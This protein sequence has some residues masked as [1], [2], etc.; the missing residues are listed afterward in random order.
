MIL[1]AHTIAIGLEN[2][3]ASA[4]ESIVNAGPYTAGVSRQT[5]PIT[6]NSSSDRK[7]SGVARYGF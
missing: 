2:A 7:C 3:R 1:N 6:G 5:D 4:P